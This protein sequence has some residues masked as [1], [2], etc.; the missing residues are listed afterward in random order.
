M[1]NE[2]IGMHVKL[3]RT[4]L[5]RD[6]REAAAEQRARDFSARARLGESF[7][8][9]MP[10][11]C[12][13]REERMSP[14]DAHAGLAHYFINGFA[15]MPVKLVNPRAAGADALTAFRAGEAKYREIKGG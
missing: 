1:D 2:L 5:A 3:A 13:D 11:F 6:A 14:V 15:G 4:M 9:E 7:A 12:A 8:R 10:G